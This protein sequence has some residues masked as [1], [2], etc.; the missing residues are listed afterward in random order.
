MAK[1]DLEVAFD[2]QFVRLGSD[3]PKPVEEYKFHPK[4]KWRIDRAWPDHKLAVEIE[5]G[6]H[7]R[8]VYCQNCGTIVRAKK[9][10]GSIGREIRVGGAHNRS[11]YLKNIEKYNTL[12][13]LGWFLLRFTHDDILADPFSMVENIRCI[14]EMREQDVKKVDYLSPNERE[15]LYLIAAGFNSMEI[16]KRLDKTQNSVRRKAQNVCE[17]LL[18]R[19]RTAAIARALVWEL[20]DP[21]EIPWPDDGKAVF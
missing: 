12:T 21:E 9:G 2:T 13:S 6:A 19:N 8:R 7:P 3:L 5:G 14:L 18:V 20:I 4:R 10:D 17:K 11:A 1:S 15:V 16:A